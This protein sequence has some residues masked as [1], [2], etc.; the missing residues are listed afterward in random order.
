MFHAEHH[1]LPWPFPANAGE[2]L[3]TWATSE[4]AEGFRGCRSPHPVLADSFHSLLGVIVSCLVLAATGQ[5]AELPRLTTAAAVARSVVA[6]A[7]PPPPV[8]LEAV[9]TYTDRDKAIFLQDQ[10]G[11]TFVL[12]RPENPRLPP[13]TRL[14]VEGVVHR[15]LF[16]NG[17]AMSRFERLGSSL[18]P[19]PKPITPQQMAAGVL[20]YDWV[21]LAGVGRSWRR[22]SE[23][24]ATLELN[25][26]GR[27]VE[28]R[29]ESVPADVALPVWVGSRLA[30]RG[31]A[32]GEINDR[33]QLIRPYLLL[34]GLDAVELVKPAP[35]DPFALPAAA[36]STLGRGEPNDGLQLVSGVAVAAP[37]QGR[38]F[39]SD[40]TAG[41]CVL[42]AD[43]GAGDA[44][45]VRVGDRVEAVGFAEAGPFATRLA[46]ARLQVTGSG[47]PVIPRRPTAKELF[48][49]C[50]GQLIEIE[51]EVVAR[52]DLA[53]GSQLELQLGDVGLR[54]LV[55]AALP[56]TIVPTA[57][58]RVTAPC[59][60]TETTNSRYS[61]RATRYDLLPQNAAAVTLL[62]RPPWWTARRLAVAL[63]ASLAVGLVAVIWS[64]LLRRQ[65]N[66]QLRLIEQ[67][68]QSEAV[69]EERQR[70][71][72]EFHDSLEQ[73]L[74]GLA[75]R[76]DSAAGS[77]ADPEARQLM[78]R[79]REILARLQEETRQYVWDL[80]EPARL[81]GSLADRVA[82][83][84][85]ELQELTDV[86]LRLTAAT[87]PGIVAPEASHQ[88]LRMLREAINNAAHHA[89]ATQIT[90]S[91]R[92]TDATLVATV[93][94][95]GEGFEPG[96][97]PIAPGHFGLCGLAERA[98][99][100]GAHVEIV[101]QPGK[102][103]AVTI[104]VPDQAGTSA[105]GLPQP[106]GR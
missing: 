73:D 56:A 26:A 61:L 50:D 17:I 103:T 47:E 95:D 42:L 84:L 58:V 40:E 83:M 104:K 93:S 55:P 59:L 105:S 37:Q 28:A 99:R 76:I 5:A 9:V 57:R 39:L 77:M 23:T 72:R 87:A 78:E 88:L 12:A 19:E 48:L 91:L 8:R 2:S 30:V 49:G 89:A 7:E 62:D 51:A 25:V 20:H 64:M 92:F 33:R 11:S 70:I 53:G 66:R 1:C 41:L 29:L 35:D 90:V 32:A 100:I 102:G 31:I 101:S 68:I 36:F 52:E 15:G 65:V 4:N 82:V 44:A 22:T 45:T 27:V 71:A 86:P 81:Q 74:A 16:I 67:Q 46:E 96:T 85:A 14:L 60:V 69:A 21:T 54:V 3:S 79:Q 94:D 43:T 98:S 10:T 75:L 97:R 6:E 18:L 63:A 13:G 106:G 24:E 80:R 38:L 34:S